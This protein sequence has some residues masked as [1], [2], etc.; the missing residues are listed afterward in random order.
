MKIKILLVGWL[1]IIF[2]CKQ[3]IVNPIDKNLLLGEWVLSKNEIN[4]PSLKFY[5]DSTAI[6]TSKADTIYRIKFFIKNDLLILKDVNNVEAT[7][8]I[9]VL[10]NNVLIFYNLLMHNT[11]QIYKRKTSI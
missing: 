4:Y 2:A 1:L 5:A 7:N 11:E 9:K 3:G 6:F 8:K 10:D